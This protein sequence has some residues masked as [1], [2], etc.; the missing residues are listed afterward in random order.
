MIFPFQARET[1]LQREKET[2]PQNPKN[3][4][5]KKTKRIIPPSQTTAGGE[6][7]QGGRK[8][9][10]ELEIVE[11]LGAETQRIGYLA[12]SPLP[13]HPA[14]CQSEPVRARSRKRQRGHLRQWWR[15]VRSRGR[16]YVC[17]GGREREGMRE[18]VTFCV[19]G[20]DSGA[21]I[22]T[23]ARRA[24]QRNG[25]PFRGNVRVRTCACTC[26]AADAR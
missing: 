19:K 4:K 8:V 6:G 7:G 17:A 16:D 5:K 13:P 2:D 22:E 10:V 14:L 11:V 21:A 25:A 23:G 12:R 18:A 20:A 15:Q 9:S 1:L 24:T 26:A 3:P